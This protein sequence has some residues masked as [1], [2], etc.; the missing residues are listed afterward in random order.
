MKKGFGYLLMAGL[1]S[2]CMSCSDNSD[3]CCGDMAGATEFSEDAIAK[4]GFSGEAPG[5]GGAIGEGG[6]AEVEQGN[7]TYS[8]LLTAGEWNDLDNWKFWT[9]LLN[10][11][12]F[13]NNTEYWGFY[14]K[15]LVAVKVI[16]E[17][18][19]GIANVSVEL[20]KGG[21]VE[22]AAKTDNTGYAYCWINL[23][24]GAA[25]DSTIEYS[26]SVDGVDYTEPLAIT[27]K[28][29][30]ELNI[31]F[32]VS[33]AKQAEA[34]ADIAFIVDATGSM[35]DEIDFLKS[36]LDD[37]IE[38]AKS[39]NNVNLRTA[40][41]VYRDE[42]DDYLT[43]YDN[44]S[45]D[46]SKTQA[47][48][49]KQ[50]AGGGGDTPEAVHSALETTLQKLSWDESARARI[51]FIILDAPAHHE[52]KII[53]SLQNSIKL[54]AKNGI[55]LIPVAASGV[56]KPAEFMLRFF[57]LA[58]G[59][60]Y[61][62]LTDD[63]G[64]GLFFDFFGKL[65][66]SRRS[67]FGSGFICSTFQAGG[68][69]RQVTQQPEQ[70]RKFVARGVQ[71][72]HERI[73][74]VVAPRLVVVLARQIAVEELLESVNLLDSRG[75]R[76]ARAL[77]ATLRTAFPVRKRSA[78]AEFIQANRNRLPQIQAHEPRHRDFALVRA[79]V[80]FLERKPAG[81]APEHERNRAVFGEQFRKVLHHSVLDGTCENAA[82]VRD[83]TG[84][85][86]DGILEPVDHMG[87]VQNIVAVC[88]RVVGIL[89]H[90]V[91]LRVDDIQFRQRIA[92]HGARD[93]AHVM[94]MF[95][96]Y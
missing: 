48:I 92:V 13:Y 21:D 46:L 63:S 67:L 17:D 9:D 71:A 70:R 74:E 6:G 54:F 41:V 59:G 68:L 8:G 56:D 37:I 80:H 1:A 26:L 24:S 36:D 20:L 58:T 18:S 31:N 64:I 55:K 79:G 11:N 50:N 38:K 12:E 25:D 28:G 61:V 22:F 87:I 75:S 95:R 32:V 94:G 88:R 30:E 27:A 15:K 39:G 35:G 44:F 10:E 76:L 7:Q 89:D 81:F 2:L 77:R 84:T 49:S 3:D 29:D 52:D 62:F 34:K 60:T 82:A 72:L 5:E 78:A 19:V 33:E 69:S 51:A 66:R 4:D 45:S 85:V 90:L 91:A 93:K 14:P 86:A 96:F 42:G 23:F 47:F 83:R 53:K 16:D 65:D 57:D 73:E 40:A 43:R